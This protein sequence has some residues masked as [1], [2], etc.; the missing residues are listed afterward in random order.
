MPSEKCETCGHDM[1]DHSFTQGAAAAMLGDLM[2]GV[3]YTRRPVRYTCV[4][5]FVL[6]Q[7]VRRMNH[8]KHRAGGA[9]AVG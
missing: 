2:S 7:Q 3:R 9:L 1:A 5:V 8:A 6:L 4:K